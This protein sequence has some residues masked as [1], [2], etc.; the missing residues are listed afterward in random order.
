MN[1]L[2]RVVVL[3][4]RFAEC[5]Q[6]PLAVRLGVHVGRGAV[7]LQAKIFFDRCLFAARQ[8][9]MAHQMGA[10]SL[11]N[12]KEWDLVEIMVFY[13]VRPTSKCGEVVDK[14]S[15]MFHFVGTDGSYYQATDEENQD[16]LLFLQPASEHFGAARAC[17]ASRVGS[18]TGAKKRGKLAKPLVWQETARGP[19]FGHHLGGDL[20]RAA[21]RMTEKLM[22]EK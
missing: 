18:A 15:W 16:L 22:T 11:D 6:R 2:E 5:L 19:A 7:Q 12:A 10:Q 9:F 20:Q 21:D 8:G 13:D 4:H 14:K 17:E 1:A 3:H